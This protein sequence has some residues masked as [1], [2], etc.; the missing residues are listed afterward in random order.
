LSICAVDDCGEKIN[1]TLTTLPVC[2]RCWVYYFDSLRSSIEELTQSLAVTRVNIWRDENVE[3]FNADSLT[4][5]EAAPTSH[6]HLVGQQSRKLRSTKHLDARASP[7]G[8]KVSGHL[9]FGN[10]SHA[11][12][13]KDVEVALI[14]VVK[15]KRQLFG[16]I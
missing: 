16:K 8:A 3:V 11:K 12:S 1:F 5:A 6:L 10:R 14:D 2:S 4:A 9:P 7:C 13:V 15:K